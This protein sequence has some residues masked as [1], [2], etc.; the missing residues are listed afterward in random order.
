M[1][2]TTIGIDLAKN[3]F[4]IHGVDKRGKVVLRKSV[5]RPALA[6]LIANL[7][8]C[9]IGME[10]CGSAHY[11]ARKFM[12]FGH[13]VKLMAP[14]FVKPYVRTNKNDAND[15]EAICEAVSRPSMRFVPV[16][17]VE[18]Q[19]VLAVHRARQGFV[20][21]RTAQVNQIRGLLYELGVVMPKGVRHLKQQLPL[22]LEDAENDLPGTSR[23]LFARLFEH[24]RELDAHVH[25]LEDQIKAWHRD[26]EA[27]RRLERIPGIGPLTASALVAS[28]GD[29]KSFKN[30]RQLA[31]WLGLVPRQASSGGK[32]RSLI[33][34]T[35]S[36]LA[37]KLLLFRGYAEPQSYRLLPR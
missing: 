5:R 35:F 28:I 6:K 22:I 9:V 25:D 1:N 11:W 7:P 14:Q 31:A 32:E 20:T 33:D 36:S 21:A 37:V 29:A 2:I 24:F 17:N 30:G 27:S 8:P 23:A 4:Q 13:T 16:K 15:A 19:S 3:V 34:M 10:A 12:E 26:S 18:Q